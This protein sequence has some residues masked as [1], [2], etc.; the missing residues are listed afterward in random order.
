MAAHVSEK[1]MYE[2][3]GSGWSPPAVPR[4]C[5]KNGENVAW[6]S[7]DDYDEEEE[8]ECSVPRLAADAFTRTKREK[9]WSYALVEADACLLVM[10]RHPSVW[11]VPVTLASHAL[12][13]VDLLDGR[14]LGIIY[15][16]FFMKPRCYEILANDKSNDKKCVLIDSR[17][18]AACINHR[19]RA[20]M[21]NAG[22]WQAQAG[23]F[24]R[25]LTIGGNIYHMDV[26]RKDSQGGVEIM[27]CLNLQEGPEGV[28]VRCMF[29]SKELGPLMPVFPDQLLGVVRQTLIIAGKFDSRPSFPAC[30]PWRCAGCLRT[31]TFDRAKVCAFC[32]MAMYCSDECRDNHFEAHE[33]EC[34]SDRWILKVD[35]EDVTSKN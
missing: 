8:E 5:L 16:A 30:P 29:Q 31:A 14:G 26:S 35:L 23:W 2:K 32:R 21:Q 27:L 11:S 19:V 10:L 22:R 34:R 20:L 13:Q 6:F 18:F 15:P 25:L 12:C 17:I 7:D 4:P 1:M 24:F 28:R 33:R 9:A 3:V